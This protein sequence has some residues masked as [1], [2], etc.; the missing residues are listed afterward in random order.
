VVVNEV[1]QWAFLTVIAFLMLGALRQI[2]LMLPPSRRATPSG[3][4]VGDRI[5]RQLITQLRR[6]FSVSELQT[7]TLVA[8]LVENCVGCQQLLT[9]LVDQRGDLGSVP[10]ALVTNRPSHQFRRAVSDLGLP[11]IHDDRGAL[12]DTCGITATP[13]V[14]RIDAE[15]R[16][17]AKEVTHRVEYVAAPTS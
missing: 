9:N 5:P 10:V 3:P 14:L 6:E 4:R 17:L 13:L 15:G 16:V 2:S 1:L 12:W 11:V 7:G 8:F